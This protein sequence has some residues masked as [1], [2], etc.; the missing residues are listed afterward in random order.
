MPL[1]NADYA[2]LLRL[3]CDHWALKLEFCFVKTELARRANFN[4]NQPRAPRGNPDG[5]QWTDVGGGSGAGQAQLISS[6]PRSGGM[7][8]IGGRLVEAT[9]AQQLRLELSAARARDA[10]RRV[11]E[12]EPNWRPTPS[13]LK[14]S[15]APSSPMRASCGK[16]K[17]GLRIL[18]CNQL[19]RI[20]HLGKSYSLTAKQ[21]GSTT[22]GPGK[23]LER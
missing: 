17:R 10:V 19:F 8:R 13:L 6:R 16:P 22:D 2:K 9:P 23:K 11:R 12:I 21:L 5:G 14:A 18:A 20:R 15:K 1:S 4:P 3:N 7:V